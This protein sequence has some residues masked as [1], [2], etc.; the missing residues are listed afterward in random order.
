MDSRPDKIRQA[1]VVN[2]WNCPPIAYI[3]LMNS[4]K[5]VFPL[6]LLLLATT[7]VHAA[8]KVP[9][10]NFEVRPILSQHCYSC[11]GPD[12]EGRKA[13]LRLDTYAGA[14]T[15]HDG[16]RAIDPENPAKSEVLHRI[17]TDDPDEIMP[18]PETKRVMTDKEKKILEAWIKSGAAYEEHWAFMAPEK[19]ELPSGKRPRAWRENPVD[20]FIYDKA[21]QA[22]LKPMSEAEKTTLIRRVTFDL[23]GLPPTPEDVEAFL[24]DKSTKA[25]EK[26]VDRLLASEQYGERM[27]LAWMDASR[28]GDSSVM[29]ADGPRTMW[30]WRDWVIRSYNDNKSFDAF[31]VEQIAGDLLPDATEDQKLAT[32]FNRNHPTSDEGGAFP[33]ELRVEYIVDRV[34]TT[35][36]IW[37]GLS[38][39]C[40]QCHDH[41]YDPIPMTEY[42]RFY[43]FFNNNADPGMQTRG[44]NQAPI[45]TLENKERDHALAENGKRQDVIRKKLDARRTSVG[46]D[47]RQWAVDRGKE[48]ESDESFKAQ[49]SGLRHHITFHEVRDKKATELFSRDGG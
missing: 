43:A 33:E 21:K 40:A 16:L 47:A 5:T 28:Y 15:L 23:T 34:K 2:G 9:D 10:F 1:G 49:P 44:G 14:T 45:V 39:E 22:G 12:E 3:Y 19:A 42:Y 36:N 26:V 27:A 29:H 18:P 17:H 48:L 8:S 38:M 25:F 6:I 4:M 41:K 31:T 32:G 13:E 46:P 7:A 20:A 11:H 24:K 37:L 30:P 35:G